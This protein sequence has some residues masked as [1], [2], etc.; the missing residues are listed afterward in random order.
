MTMTRSFAKHSRFDD[1][2]RA[3][4]TPLSAANRLPKS[5][6]RCLQQTIGNRAVQRFLNDH[7]AEREAENV[8]GGLQPARIGH[9]LQGMAAPETAGQPA[10]D[11]ALRSAGRPLDTPTRNLFEPMFGKRF[12]SVRVHTDST[13]AE[14]ARAVHAQAYTVGSDIVFGA[15]Y[16]APETEIGR[17]LLAHELTHVV[18]Q[19][20]SPQLQAKP[21]ETPVP[22]ADQDMKETLSLLED[23]ETALDGFF[24]RYRIWLTHNMILFLSDIAKSGKGEQGLAAINSS[25]GEGVLKEAVVNAISMG[26][27][28]LGAA[29]G[30]KQL[31]KYFLTLRAA[32][33]VGGIFSF[34]VGA[35]LEY[36]VGNLFDQTNA[37]ID[38][39]ASQIDLLVNGKLNPMVNAKERTIRNFISRSRK[40]FMSLPLTH[41][42]WQA[43]KKDIIALTNNAAQAILDV[44]DLSLYRKAALTA[45]VFSGGVVTAEDKAPGKLPAGGGDLAFFIQKVG[46]KKPGHTKIEALQDNSTITLR[47]QSHDCLKDEGEIYPVDVATSGSVAWM[48]P[49]PDREYHVELYQ[50]GT[51]TNST[52]SIPRVFQVGK[53]QWGIWYN[54]P[55]GT[56]LIFVERLFSHPVALCGAGHYWVEAPPAPGSH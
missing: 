5:D 1:V 34:V 56:Y 10:V 42:E 9:A 14:S 22:A 18:Q 25:F 17:R 31:A 15:G 32:K 12:E 53:E 26:G 40:D 16:Y 39:T 4:R 50:M 36:L 44:K 48:E 38:A 2:R 6:A 30:G 21:L 27:V 8:A 41:E 37:I 52:L 45:D 24:E 43:E 19:E 47:L 49:W 55:K 51:F 28:E 20:H 35:I 13:A 46:L 23:C 29:Y 7:A 54:V 3:V 33:A 11:D